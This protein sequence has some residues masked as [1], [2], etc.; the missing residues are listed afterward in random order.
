MQAKRHLTNEIH[1]EKIGLVSCIFK[2]VGSNLT[3]YKKFSRPNICLC[4][5]TAAAASTYE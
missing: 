4:V 5:M 2:I 3:L 1:N